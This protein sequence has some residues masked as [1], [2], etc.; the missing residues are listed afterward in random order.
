MTDSARIVKMDTRGNFILSLPDTGSSPWE[1]SADD[2]RFNSPQGITFNEN[3]SQMY[4]ADTN[5]RR[6]QI[7]SFD[8]AGKPVHERNIGVTGQPGSDNSQF[9]TPVDVVYRNGSI[10]VVDFDNNRI[11]KCSQDTGV[12]SLYLK[13]L[14]VDGNDSQ[15]WLPS[16]LAF[17]LDYLIV[18]DGLNARVLRCPL[19]GDDIDSQNCTQFAGTAGETGRDDLHFAWPDDVV[20]DGADHVY[21]SDID[22]HRVI[23]YNSD[24]QKQRQLGV[25][26]VPYLTADPAH[27][28]R[29]LLNAPWGIISDTTDGGLYIAENKGLRLIKM[30]ANGGVVW[31]QGEAGIFGGDT[32]HFGSYWAFPEG[33]LG[34]DSH[35]RIYVPDTGNQ[36]VKIYLPDGTLFGQIGET[37]VGGVDQTHFNCPAG[38]AVDPSNDSIYVVDHCNQRVQVFDSNRNYKA[39]LGETGVIGSDAAHFNWPWGIAVDANHRVYVA[40]L[41]NHRVMKCT[42]SGAGGVCAPFAGVAGATGYDTRFESGPISVAVGPD[43]L[44]YI[45]ENWSNRVQVFDSNG[46]F[47]T[48]FA[49]G[50]GSAHGQLVSPSG[51]TVDAHNNVYM[52]DTG[53]HRVEVFSLGVPGWKQLNLNGFGSSLNPWAPAMAVFKGKL[54]AGVGGMQAP[55]AQIWRMDSGNTWTPAVRDGFGNPESNWVRDLAVFDGYLYAGVNN[56]DTGS[57]VWRSSD[58]EHWTKVAV[59]GFD[60]SPTNTEVNQFLVDGTNL[61]ASTFTSLAEPYQGARIYQYR[62][63]PNNLNAWDLITPQNGFGDDNN[64]GILSMARYN[65]FLYAGTY[66]LVSGAELWRMDL[67][68]NLW[69]QVDPDGFGSSDTFAFNSLTVFQGK[70]YLG[71]RNEASGGELWSYTDGDPAWIK[72][73][74]DFNKPANRSIQ[75]LVQYGTDLY[76]STSTYNPDD[77]GIEVWHS[78]NGTSWAQVPGPSGFGSA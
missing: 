65:N 71:T 64:I 54:Y 14:V 42:V 1:T 24:G 32:A 55:S 10:Y 67:S 57:Q 20:I 40:D 9:A 38:V 47:R 11:Q 62:N 78:G 75:G 23:V 77:G 51:I 13:D 39:T 22:N 58:G 66:N 69:S 52:A 30:D 19:N 25:T 41:E 46:A 17:G 35:R 73:A 29:T 26:A 61:Y 43:G 45:L 27:P 53:N 70:L 34:I 31:T 44:V 37:A 56:F 2:G 7:F 50:G 21:V 8:C 72:V 3:G 74:G 15:L 36:R 48:S 76:L 49:G 12:C 59:N 18:T 68:S 28:D 63:D 60:N 4:V 33:S 5:N 16:G 6:V